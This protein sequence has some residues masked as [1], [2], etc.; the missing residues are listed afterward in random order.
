MRLGSVREQ[1][2]QERLEESPEGQDA[3]NKNNVDDK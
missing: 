3:K 2:T 1:A